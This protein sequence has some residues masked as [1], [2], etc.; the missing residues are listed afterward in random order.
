MPGGIT[1]AHYAASVA[2]PL[3]PLMPRFTGRRRI[4]TTKSFEMCHRYSAWTYAVNRALDDLVREHGAADVAAELRESNTFSQAACRLGIDL[5]D[6]L[7]A[8]FEIVDDDLMTSVLD[9]MANGLDQGL[10]PLL[11]WQPAKRW[12]AAFPP[13]GDG[14]LPIILR[15]PWPDV[16]ATLQP[17]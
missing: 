17:I 3:V 1:R 8:Y 14:V 16:R 2:L 6:D 10:L 9:D 5:P 15:G 12:S 7:I 4:R 11:D 13:P